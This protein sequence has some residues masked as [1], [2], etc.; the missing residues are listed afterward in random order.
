MLQDTPDGEYL[1]GGSKTAAGK[2]RVVTLS[3]KIQP[4]IQKYAAGKPDE[5]F[6]FP[7]ES[8][9]KFSDKLFRNRFYSVLETLS[10]PRLSPHCCRHTFATLMKQVDAPAMDKQK[11]IGHASFEMTAHYTHTNHEDLRKITD[12]L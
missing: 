6:L 11:L 10:L 8:G 4:I 3:P 9:G 1:I 12:R 2:N 5:G 7:N